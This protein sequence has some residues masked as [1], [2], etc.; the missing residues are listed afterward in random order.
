M[1][2]MSIGVQGRPDSKKMEQNVKN[3][4]MSAEKDVFSKYHPFFLANLKIFFMNEFVKV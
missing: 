3:I 1:I 4:N 2:P